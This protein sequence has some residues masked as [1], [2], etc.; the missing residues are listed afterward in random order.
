MREKFIAEAIVILL[1]SIFYF[2]SIQSMG[3]GAHI[4]CILASQ[5]NGMQTTLHM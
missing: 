5:V 1:Q 2:I 4:A 3:G